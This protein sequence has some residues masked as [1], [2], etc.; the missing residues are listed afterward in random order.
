M[1]KPATISAVTKTDTPIGRVIQALHTVMRETTDMFTV[2][3]ISSL[4]M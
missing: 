2:A 3:A 1:T 4:M